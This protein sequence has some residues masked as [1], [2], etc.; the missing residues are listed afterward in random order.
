MP[1]AT[2]MEGSAIVGQTS[3][4]EIVIDV[5]LGL[6]ALG[7]VDANFV[8]AIFK[9]LLM[10]SAILRP[11]SVRV[12]MVPM[13]DNVTHVYLDT[14]GS[15]IVSSASV[16][17]ILMNAIPLLESALAAGTTLKVTTVKDVWQDIMEIP[18]LVQVITA[19]LAHAQMDLE[20][21]ASLLVGVIK[22]L[23]L[24]MLYVHATK[25]IQVFAVMGV[26][27]AIMETRRRMVVSVNHVTATIT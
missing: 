4:E 23:P 3:L 20:A 8:N 25:V 27:L 18:D 13:E 14:G 2:L 10:P 7:Q 1:Y 5:N 16:M 19:D 11:A 26:P 15:R 9:D 24:S 21:G 12:S 22:T 6:T 17:D